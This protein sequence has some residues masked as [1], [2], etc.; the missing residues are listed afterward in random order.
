MF[1]DARSM[2]GRPTVRWKSDAP[3]SFMSLRKRSIFCM[4]ERVLSGEL[5]VPSPGLRVLG[6]QHS[7]RST[8][9]IVDDFPAVVEF[10]EQEREETV[11]RLPFFHGQLPAA[12]DEGVLV[13]DGLDAELAEGQRPHLAPL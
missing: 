7:A 8:R 13:V 4:T 9:V 6:T 10:S 12:G 5:R 11:R 1:P 3:R 2:G